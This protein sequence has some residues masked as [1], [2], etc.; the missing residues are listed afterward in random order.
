MLLLFYWKLYREPKVHFRHIGVLLKGR[1]E[2]KSFFKV[3]NSEFWGRG[4]GTVQQ[5][6][7]SGTIEMCA[8]SLYASPVS[9]DIHISQS[10]VKTNE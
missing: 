2:F 6:D 9:I 3:R 4:F 7:S 5:I 1:I 8:Q 10:P